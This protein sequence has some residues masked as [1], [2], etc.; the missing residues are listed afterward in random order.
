MTGF[1]ALPLAEEGQDDNAQWVGVSRIMGPRW[2]HLPTLTIGLL[3]CQVLWSVEMS[4]GA[5]H[6]L[7]CISNTDIDL[8]NLFE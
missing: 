6:D 2:A 7:R 8:Y 4:Y 1:S 5:F 3:G